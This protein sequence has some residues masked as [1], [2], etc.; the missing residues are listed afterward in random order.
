MGSLGGKTFL[1]G[2]IR[3]SHRVGRLPPRF[4]PGT[5]FPP[6]G[7]LA[8]CTQLIMTKG[9]A[10]SKDVEVKTGTI[11]RQRGIAMP[12]HMVS[13][14]PLP[15][16]LNGLFD[17]R[18]WFESLAR[19]VEYKPLN[20]DYMSERMLA[21]TLMSGSVE[22][23]LSPKNLTG[24]QDL[25]PNTPGATSGPIRIT[26]IY[27]DKSDQEDGNRCYILFSFINL[28]TGIETTT[29]TGATQVQAVFLTWLAL[30][31]WPIE[32][33]ITRGDRTDRGGRYMFLIQPVE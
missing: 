24:L 14:A 32:C 18:A 25:I 20:P 17:L 12:A 30:G 19:K 16:E 7:G 3:L 15:A 4:F 2:A 6:H 28:E 10:V 1:S 8:E 13:P 23:L 21:L 27:V 33:R 9:H 26:E 29:T 5:A 31:Q 22:E 11:V